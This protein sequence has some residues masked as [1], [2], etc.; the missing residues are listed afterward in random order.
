M[1]WKDFPETTPRATDRVH[2]CI[3]KSRQ[4]VRAVY[5]RIGSPAKWTK[6]GKVCLNCSQF[7]PEQRPLL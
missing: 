4:P 7:W 1:P 2:R 3:D 5:T 6:V